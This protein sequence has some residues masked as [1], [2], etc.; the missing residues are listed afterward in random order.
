MLTSGAFYMIVDLAA[1]M[2][3]MLWYIK[4]KSNETI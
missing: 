2:K 3:S 4:A 1:N